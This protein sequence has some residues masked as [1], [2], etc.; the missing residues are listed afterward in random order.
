MVFWAHDWGKENEETLEL[1]V[2]RCRRNVLAVSAHDFSVFC[3]LDSV[4]QAQPGKLMDYSWVE[5]RK[6]NVN[7]IPYYGPAWYHRVAV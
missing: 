3:P 6:A 5:L 2:R 4:V 7:T 1:D